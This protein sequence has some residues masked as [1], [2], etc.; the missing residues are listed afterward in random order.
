VRVDWHLDESIVIMPSDTPVLGLLSY[1]D[2][3]VVRPMTDIQLW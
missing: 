3:M 2:R 1:T